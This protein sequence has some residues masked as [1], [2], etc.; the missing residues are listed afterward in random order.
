[1][2]SIYKWKNGKGIQWGNNWGVYDIQN[3]TIIVHSYSKSGFLKAWEL[4]E[5]RY[6]IIDRNSI[7][8]IFFKVRTEDEYYKSNSPWINVSP[9]HFNPAD[10]IPSSDN[11]LKENKWIWRNESDWKAYMDRIKIEKKKK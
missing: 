5:D 7:K 3:D 6:K 2:S 1:M 10:S 8:R 9:I 11:W 4:T